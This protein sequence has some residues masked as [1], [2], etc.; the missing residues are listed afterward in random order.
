MC[1][2]LSDIYAMGITEIDHVLAILGLSDKLDKS[3]RLEVARE[4]TKGMD[5]KAREAGTQISGGQTVLNP[6]VITGGSVLGVVT[7]FLVENRKCEE[8]DFIVLTKPLGNQLVINF[9]QYYRKNTRFVERLEKTGF[10]DR[11]SFLKIFENCVGSMTTLNLY[12]AKVMGKFGSSIRACTDITGFGIK[13]HSDN[14]L[15]IQENN[16]DFEFH[17]FPVFGNVWKL[18]KIVRD[19]KL[20]EGLAAETSGGL[21]IVM[22]KNVEEE[23]RRDLLETYGIESWVIGKVVKGN[24]EYCKSKDFKFLEVY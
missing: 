3:Q 23:Y 7:D 11:N 17:T 16:V 18:D 2:I 12:A 1:N 20:E 14:L 22:D 15:D 13:G 9:E 21:M 6:W 24:R 8:G 19:F 5:L 4:L 10:L